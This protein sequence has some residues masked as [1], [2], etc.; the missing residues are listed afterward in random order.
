[1]IGIPTEW[2]NWHSPHRLVAG[3]AF[4]YSFMREKT[5][6]RKEM[7]RWTV[8]R[9]EDGKKC[10]EKYDPV[11]LDLRGKRRFFGVGMFID[12]VLHRAIF[13]ADL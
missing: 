2:H 6:F 7:V 4:L 11:F 3:Y 13:D 8:Y 1:M 5:Y 10:A 12:A 9:D